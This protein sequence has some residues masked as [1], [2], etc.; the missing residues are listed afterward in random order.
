VSQTVRILLAEDNAADVWLIKEALKRQ[1]L[2]HEIENH[3]TAEDAIEAI[4]RCGYGDKAVPDLILLDYNLPKGH[5]G[6]VL[7]AAVANPKLA[8][9]PKAILSSFMQPQ[10]IESM[11]RLGVSCF[12]PKPASLH[13]FLRD[14]GARVK[15][16]LSST[17]AT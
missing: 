15:E 16:L 8:G 10:E 13:D 2:E 4:R 6:E 14:V 1:S 11:L 12:I 9:V 5:G 7:A 3:T 17:C